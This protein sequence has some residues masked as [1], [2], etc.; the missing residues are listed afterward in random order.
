MYLFKNTQEWRGFHFK[1]PA[2]KD[3]NLEMLSFVEER[4]INSGHLQWPEVF[5]SPELEPRFAARLREIVKSH[6]G[7]VV[8]SSQKATHIIEPKQEGDPDEDPDLEYLRTID[9]HNRMNLVHWWYYPDSY[10]TWLPATDVQGEQPDPEPHKKTWRVSPRFL[11]DLEQFNEWMNELDYDIDEDEQESS[12]SGSY[13]GRG[14]GKG[15]KGNRKRNNPLEEEEVS[16]PRKEAKKTKLKGK[17]KEEDEEDVDVEGDDQDASKS[18]KKNIS[19]SPSTPSST[20]KDKRVSKK[21][22]S[23][24]PLKIKFSREVVVCTASTFEFINLN[25]K[26]VA[27]S[28]R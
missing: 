4:L 13:P 5:L 1:T 12:E 2:K 7:K 14:K 27:N 23:A 22:D 24:E 26:T 15:K 19:M 20:P 11:T 9:H 18:G 25:Q 17:R 21:E 16:T 6:R 3:R 28:N 10:D 8:S